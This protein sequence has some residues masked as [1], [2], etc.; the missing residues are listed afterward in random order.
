M[1]RAALAALMLL[2]SVPGGAEPIWQ[3][4]ESHQIELAIRD[5]NPSGNYTVTFFVI[6]PDGQKLTVTRRVVGDYWS[7]VRYPHDF[8]TDLKPGKYS[9]HG[10]VN[11]VAAVGGHFTYAVNGDL[12]SLTSSIRRGR[13]EGPRC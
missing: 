5:R 1:L 12:V 8:A 11:G 4:S 13:L 7:S 6:D 10:C 9:W 2:A 3:S